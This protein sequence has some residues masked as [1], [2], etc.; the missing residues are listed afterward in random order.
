MTEHVSDPEFDLPANW[1]IAPLSPP[2]PASTAVAGG[3]LIAGTFRGLPPR[4]GNALV[5]DLYG[6]APSAGAEYEATISLDYL[7]GNGL[8]TY[9]GVQLWDETDGSVATTV[10]FVALTADPLLIVAAS[11]LFDVYSISITEVATDMK[12]SDIR[13]GLRSILV[14]VLSGPVPSIAFENRGHTPAEGVPWAR[15]TLLPNNVR[16]TAFDL[17]QLEGIYQVDIFW[18]SNDGTEIPE[19]LADDLRD[20]F[21]PGTS[22]TAHANVYRSERTLSRQEPSWYI[23][24]VRVY[25]RAFEFTP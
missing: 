9:G 6:L 5:T 1:G 22:L 8:I 15:E 19:D 23:L 13:K 12:H 7:T 21:L 25:W 2:I 17:N 18:P 10:P 24:S 11:A 20:A 3:Q 16:R 14:G 4:F